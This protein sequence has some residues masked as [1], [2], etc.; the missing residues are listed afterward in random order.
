[1]HASEVLQRCFGSA[2]M[3]MH[4]R[5]RSVLMQ[6]VDALVDGRR[7]T[8]TDLAR[9]WPGAERIAAPLKKL[10][11]LLSNRHLAAETTDLYAAVIRWCIRQPRPVIVVDWS[12]LDSKGRFHLLRAA[13]AVGGRTLTLWERV[14]P[15]NH[16][17]S[18]KHER[19]LLYALREA[20]PSHVRPILVTDAGFRAP[21]FQ[22]VSALGWDFVGRLRHR[23]LV[24]PMGVADEREQWVP[25]RMLYALL[26]GAPRDL[27]LFDVV[28]NRPVQCRLVVHRK[29]RQGRLQLTRHGHRAKGTNSRENAEREAE[30]WLLATSIGHSE[31]TAT[32]IVALYARRMQIEQGF[33]D[34]KSHRYGVGFEDSLTRVKE[35]LGILLVLHALA[36]FAIWIAAKSAAPQA[37]ATAT[38]AIV[39]RCKRITVSWHRVGSLLLRQGRWRFD[40]TT[41]QTLIWRDGNALAVA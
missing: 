14:V 34:L 10:D 6:A 28:R 31:L 39:R 12:E 18:P 13:L 7:L 38:D 8:L 20:I 25:C 24:K 5:R 15:A 3:P 35:R 27:G 29:P 19:D 41:A 32:Q 33:R 4:A 40:L 9:S 1:M 17:N 21:W 22:A 30:P 11:R 26:T 2:L 36:C 23:M 37:I 16:T